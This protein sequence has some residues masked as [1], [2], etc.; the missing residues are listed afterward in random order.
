[1]N[2]VIRRARNAKHN[3]AGAKYS[4]KAN[5][6]GMRAACERTRTDNRTV[7][8]KNIRQKAVKLFSALVGI[9]VTCGCIKIGFV[10]PVF[11]ESGKHLL[12]IVF[13]DFINLF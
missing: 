10:N 1:M 6:E 11:N 12:L 5:A 2:S 8:L 7:R 13:G 3:V 9:A 4:E